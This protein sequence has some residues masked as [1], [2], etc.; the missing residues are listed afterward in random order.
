MQNAAVDGA[1]PAPQN[2]ND[3]CRA[4][5]SDLVSLVEHVQN[6]LR[7]VEQM[8]ARET[9]LETSAETSPATPESS[10]NIIVLDDV[11]PRYMRTGAA[12]QACHVNPGIALR[13]LPDASD[14]DPCAASLPAHSVIGA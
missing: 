5:V 9:S 2:Q 14:S 4:V 8:I 6:S 10:T 12:L 1:A 13:S 7:L 3:A 11:S